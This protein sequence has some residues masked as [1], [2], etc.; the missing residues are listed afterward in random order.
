MQST[1]L[2]AGKGCGGK[3]PV[4][5]AEEERVGSPR[6]PEGQAWRQLHRLDPGGR[7][8]LS[9]MPVWVG[10]GCV[11]AG[12][13]DQMGAGCWGI[14]KGRGEDRPPGAEAGISP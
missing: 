13:P 9:R 8:C 5:P 11:E 14:R 4:C 1:P 3:D 6:E 2:S 10:L 7:A 12:G